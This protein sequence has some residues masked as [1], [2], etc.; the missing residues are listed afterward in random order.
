LLVVSG[1]ILIPP[2]VRILVVDA[3]EPGIGVGIDLVE[4]GHERL[5][6]VGVVKA[7]T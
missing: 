6:G 7:S 3:I 1:C 5:R 4:F 2:I